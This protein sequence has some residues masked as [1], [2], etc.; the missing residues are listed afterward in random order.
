MLITKL[1]LTTIESTQTACLNRSEFET[2]FNDHYSRLCSYAYNFL[3]EEEGSEEVVQEVFFKL[4]INRTDIQIQSSMESYLYRSVRNASL[5][6][7]K[8]ISIREKYKEHNQKEI[9]YAENIDKDPMNAS[10]LE[11][12]IR[13]SIDL[14]PEQRRKIFL[15]SRYEQLKYKEIAEQLGISVKTV[16]NQMGKALQF[17]RNELVDY[18]PLIFLFFNHFF[19]GE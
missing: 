3:K 6:L 19:K 2:L 11:L 16:E 5:N 14:L 9:E 7:I 1:T 15:L 12:K 4:W 13:A 18:L 17:L 10:E 8:H